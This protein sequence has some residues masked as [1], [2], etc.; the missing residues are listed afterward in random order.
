QFG[1]ITQD[2]VTALQ[3]MGGGNNVPTHVFTRDG[4]PPRRQSAGVHSPDVQSNVVPIM[5]SMGAYTCL[6]QSDCHSYWE[7]NQYTDWVFPLYE[8]P[9]TGGFADEFA[10]GRLAFLSSVVPGSGP[11]GTGPIGPGF[12]GGPPHPAPLGDNPASPRARTPRCAAVTTRTTPAIPTASSTRAPATPTAAWC[13]TTS[14]RR[15]AC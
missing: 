12:T 8:L 3:A 6:Q 1:M 5:L 10:Q 15:S 2:D 14:T 7:F 13:S 11:A 4:I 9:F